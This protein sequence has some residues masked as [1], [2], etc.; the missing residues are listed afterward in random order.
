[1]QAVT[2]RLASQVRRRL[3]SLALSASTKTQTAAMIPSTPKVGCA[4]RT[5]SL[6]GGASL[7]A[8]K[9]RSRRG[10]FIDPDQ[11]TRGPRG[12]GRS[13][14]VRTLWGYRAARYGL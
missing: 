3:A 8:S 12:A 1:M 9:L 4:N 5:I 6:M 13:V 11:T 2:A 7:A 14:S 10:Q